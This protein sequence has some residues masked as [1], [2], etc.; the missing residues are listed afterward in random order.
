VKIGRIE[1]TVPDIIG[2]WI[3]E[4]VWSNKPAFVLSR[5]SGL[6]LVDLM[7]FDRLQTIYNKTGDRLE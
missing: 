2:Q 3:I 1:K 7:T 5:N 4:S 6:M